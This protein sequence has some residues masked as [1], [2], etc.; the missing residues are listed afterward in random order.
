MTNYA[1]LAIRVYA[2]IR[3]PLKFTKRLKLKKLIYKR[4][5]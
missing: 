5:G 4:S 2:A 1:I 3:I